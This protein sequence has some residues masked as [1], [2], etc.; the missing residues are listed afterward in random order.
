[1]SVS[2]PTTT[3][4]Q[5]LNNNAED[6][7]DV[8]QSV[9]HAALQKTLVRTTIHTYIQKA[10]Y[11]YTSID[12]LFSEDSTHLFKYHHI[13][14][15]FDILVQMSTYAHS[16]IAYT[17]LRLELHLLKSQQAPVQISTCTCPHL[18]IHLS[19]SQHTPVQISTYACF[20]PSILLLKSQHTPALIPAYSCSNLTIRL[21]R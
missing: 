4:Q 18:N 2:P 21:F 1:M 11:T 7:C 9:D 16:K 8:S 5:Q 20:N 19:K 6:R 12:T 17:L 14:F 10:A 13:T 15:K 3:A